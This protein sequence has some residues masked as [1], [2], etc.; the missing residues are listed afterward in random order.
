MFEWETNPDRITSADIAVG[1]ASYNEADSISYP[2]LQAD[3]GLRQYF[4]ELKPVIINCDNHSPDNTAGAFL[5]T[6]TKV[7]QDLYYHSA[8]TP[9]GKAII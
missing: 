8:R 5:E 7:E 6:T 4:P 3:L 2:T 9:R 1:L